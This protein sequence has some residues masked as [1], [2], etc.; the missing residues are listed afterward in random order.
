MT[1]TQL[2]TPAQILEELQNLGISLVRKGDKVLCRGARERLPADLREQIRELRTELLDLL[3]VGNGFG[4][5]PRGQTLDVEYTLV[6]DIKAAKQVAVLLALEKLLGLDIETYAVDPSLSVD[7][8]KPALDPHNARIRLI[9]IAIAHRTFIFDTHVLPLEELIPVL[10]PVLVGG[11]VKVIHNVMFEGQFFLAV[12]VIL[13]PVF[14][15]QMADQLITSATVPDW[16][17]RAAKGPPDSKLGM[18]SLQVVAMAYL[19]VWLDKSR[20]SI[21]WGGLLSEEDIEYAAKD[22]ATLLPLHGVM[23]E[24][25]IALGLMAVADLEDQAVLVMVEVAYYGVWLDHQAL[26]QIV[27]DMKAEKVRLAALLIQTAVSAG[28]PYIPDNWGSTPQRQRFLNELLGTQL[29]ST[30]KPV[31]QKLRGENSHPIIPALQEYLTVCGPVSRYGAAEEGA[32]KPKGWLRW[33]SP[34]TGRVHAD[35]HPLGC[36]T[37]RQSC[38]NP[39]LQQVPRDSIYRAMFRPAAPPPESI[40]VK[41]DYPQLELRL[42]ADFSGDP[43]MSRALTEEGRDIHLEAGAAISGKDI[44]E[45]NYY[46]PER[47]YGKTANYC[48]EYG[49]GAE[50]F[51]K[52]GIKDGLT[53]TL[54]EAEVA[55]EA[56]FRGFAGLR[57]WQKRQGGVALSVTRW[58]RQRN[59]PEPPEDEKGDYSAYTRRLNSPVQGT[60]ADGLKL[61]LVELLNTRTPELMDC[62][63]VLVT[64]DEIVI[65]CPLEKRGIVTEWLRNAMVTGMN[66][67]LV[68]LPFKSGDIEIKVCSNYAGA[69]LADAAEKFLEPQKEDQHGPVT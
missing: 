62:H 34:I 48:L 11:P 69:P 16:Q 15:T 60:G 53:W 13:S 58:G 52:Q 41:G 66:K 28:A 50:R 21:Y 1:P 19:G 61:A 2:L 63:P 6:P 20:Q 23:L 43:V 31:L 55:R 12:G 67:V 49:A 59:L 38:S 39:P 35:W 40:Y 24:R 45:L 56:Y 8:A 29:T 32:K 65:E 26:T 51:W 42:G 46:S 30:A 57:A 7:P 68:N 9:Q 14:D 47:Q 10:A 27:N 36:D 44:Q 37:G 3:A 33:V 22:S 54:L 17:L 18:R 64:H 5:E 4:P 25:L